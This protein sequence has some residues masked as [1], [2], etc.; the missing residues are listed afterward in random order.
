[1]KHL[2]TA[3]TTLLLLSS[4][5]LADDPT[6]AE[7]LRELQEL[8]SRMSEL[9]G[10][11][12][13]D[14]SDE[15]ELEGML[16]ESSLDP[17]EDDSSAKPGTSFVRN[18]LSNTTVGGYVS[19]EFENFEDSDSAFDQH[20]L[21][22][23]VASQVHKRVRFYSEIEL[24]H[25]PFFGSEGTSEG[26]LSIDDANGNGVIDASEAEDL[27]FSGNTTSG[28][29]GELEVEQAWVQF[30]LTE[31]LGV[32]TGVI[33]VPFGRFNLY[34]DDDLQN[35]TDRPLVARRVIP[36][37]WSD[38]G[39]GFV[40]NWELGGEATLGG[41]F[42]FVNG[43]DDEFSGGRGGLRGA[44]SSRESDNNND[45]AV[46]GRLV[47]SPSLGHEFG[48]S[49]YVGDYDDDNNSAAGWAF[50]WLM[51][52]GD[53]RLVG[54]YA[55][56]GLDDGSNASGA[57]APS[58]ISGVYAELNYDFWCD[59][60]DSSFLGADF[61]DPKF[62]LSYR[63]NYAAIDRR[64]QATLDETSHVVGLAYRPIDSFV[65]KTE[66]QFNEGDLER[67]DADGFIGS[68]ALGF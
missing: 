51:T 4:S 38:A 33:L 58:D 24:E 64:E 20:R 1:M 49:G 35:L 18:I 65:V 67:S 39:L 46:V 55:Y 7:L 17:E 25:G 63:Y 42:Y 22:L 13:S 21:V 8:K 26:V 45:K 57:R 6:Q 28:E 41:E 5:A 66:W 11:I 56:F 10:K 52:Y 61:E 60:L 29:S 53:I 23:N 34:H 12:A 32:R 37:T 40:G 50:D 16:D 3:L 19:S 14:E 36:S 68:F 9:E 27:E 2:I 30:D 44:R 15:D 54:E 43:L 62:V 48:L 59:Y 47:A 31:R